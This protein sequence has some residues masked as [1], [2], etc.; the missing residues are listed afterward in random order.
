MLRTTSFDGARDSVQLR[1]VQ[2][3]RT[4]ASH[5]RGSLHTLT[6]PHQIAP[7]MRAALESACTS[8]FAQARIGTIR[9][10]F[11]LAGVAR[12]D[13]RPVALAPPVAQ[14]Q[15]RRR[16][17]P[18]RCPAVAAGALPFERTP[19]VAGS[20]RAAHDASLADVRNWLKAV[21][22]VWSRTAWRGEPGNRDQR[23]SSTPCSRFDS[24][25]E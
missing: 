17:M 5:L 7:P 6:K 18:I 10:T 12:Q 20:T 13:V 24:H 22:A 1:Y 23:A 2:R 8:G 4:P 9:A 3:L 15:W 21:A 19:P 14:V 16:R 11:R 25:H